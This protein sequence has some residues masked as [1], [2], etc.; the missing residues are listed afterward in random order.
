MIL[1]LCLPSF[2]HKMLDIQSAKFYHSGATMLI[3]VK[4]NFHKTVT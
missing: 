1:A 2:R 3:E 4:K